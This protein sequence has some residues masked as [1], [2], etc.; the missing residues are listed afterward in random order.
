MPIP[1]PV[2]WPVIRAASASTYGIASLDYKGQQ[3]IP[4]RNGAAQRRRKER[5]LPIMLVCFQMNTAQMTFQR[6]QVPGVIRRGPAPSSF[7]AP[8][9]EWWR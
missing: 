1:I 3:S 4:L 9:P 2:G 6:R 7:R 5:Q 8:A